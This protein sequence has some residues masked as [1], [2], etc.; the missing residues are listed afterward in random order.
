M[1]HSRLWAVDH[2]VSIIFTTIVRTGIKGLMDYQDGNTGIQLVRF[3]GLKVRHKLPSDSNY[4]AHSG[5][6]TL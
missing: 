2:S 5:A 1:V 4:N 3:V 6:F